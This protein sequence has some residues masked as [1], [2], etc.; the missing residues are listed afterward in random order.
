MTGV[1]LS[2]I[3]GS[4]RVTLASKLMTGMRLEA[5]IPFTFKSRPNALSKIPDDSPLRSKIGLHILT[6]HDAINSTANKHRFISAEAIAKCR[7]WSQEI[8]TRKAYFLES[9][10][11]EWIEHTLE[12]IRESTQLD[13]HL[14]ERNFILLEEKSKEVKRD[15]Y[16]NNHRHVSRMVA[17]AL[18]NKL[19]AKRIA[20]TAKK[21][22]PKKPGEEATKPSMDPAE[23]LKKAVA[24]KW[25]KYA[26]SYWNGVSNN[27]ER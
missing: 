15:I 25:H 10:W 4:H 11:R 23:F 27:I 16:L 7:H 12:S 6:P 21:Y 2:I 13:Q 17:D 14:D 8:A 18:V 19:P 1:G 26:Y 22:V 24:G 20:A 5:S 9:P 3:E